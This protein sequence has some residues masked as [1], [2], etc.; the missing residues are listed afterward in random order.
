[1][2]FTFLRFVTSFCSALLP[3]SLYR[4]TCNA[5]PHLNPPAGGGSAVL[6]I[7][8]HWRGNPHRSV[9]CTLRRTVRSTA[10]HTGSRM[11]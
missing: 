4:F 6:V 11:Q 9:P 7:G 5:S 8:A 1:M 10:I 2:F 3:G